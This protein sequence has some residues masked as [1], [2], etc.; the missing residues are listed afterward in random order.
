VD[1]VLNAVEL[2]GDVG[3]SGL[4]GIDG[5]GEKVSGFLVGLNSLGFSESLEV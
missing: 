3:K 1:L 4:S 2:N 5:D